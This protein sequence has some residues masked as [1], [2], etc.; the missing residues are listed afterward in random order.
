MLAGV[1]ETGIQAG[2]LAWQGDQAAL[3]AVAPSRALMLA[4]MQ[5]RG[6]KLPCFDMVGPK[7]GP[8]CAVELVWAALVCHGGAR[9]V[10]CMLATWKTCST[11]VIVCIAPIFCVPALLAGVMSSKLLGWSKW[12]LLTC[13]QP[14][15]FV[16]VGTSTF[17]AKAVAEACRLEKFEAIRAAAK[18]LEELEPATGI[19]GATQPAA[20]AAA[21]GGEEHIAAGSAATEILLPELLAALSEQP[22][23]LPPMPA[24]LPQPFLLTP[25]A[26]V[27][28]GSTPF[29]TAG[30]ADVMA[31]FM[32][33]GGSAADAAPSYQ[34]ACPGLGGDLE[35]GR[36]TRQRR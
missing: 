16:Q 30:A 3:L 5:H 28:A 19:A 15:A 6:V 12:L 27:G 18:L 4:V 17:L 11:V 20:L 32:V 25:E 26:L 8:H 1:L 36:R 22:R 10:G 14:F 31:A 9:Q 13:C 34:H 2:E 21:A 7:G 35:D 24:P 29:G 33:A 23:D